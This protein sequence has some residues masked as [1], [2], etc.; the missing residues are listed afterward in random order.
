MQD[1]VIFDLDGTLV[2]LR[3]DSDAFE[4]RRA[5][6]ASYLSSRGVPT[7]L[8]PLLPELQRVAHTPLGSTVRADILQSF[9]ALELACGYRCLGDLEAILST[10]Q[11]TF[12]TLVLVTHNSLACW[13]RLARENTWPHLFD[14]VITRDHMTFFKPDPRAC[15]SVFQALTLRSCSAEC[16]V[17]GNS[18]ADRGLGI[19]LRRAYP[20]LVVRTIMIDPTCAPGTI[21]PH[22]LDVSLKSVDSVLDLW[23]STIRTSRSQPTANFSST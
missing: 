17:V 10:L 2:D 5:F 13:E 12:R 9:D 6:W 18:E 1:I 3:I 11:S 8:R 22:E 21:V 7:T 4:A 15:A 14:V 16:W 19:N 20:H 23:T